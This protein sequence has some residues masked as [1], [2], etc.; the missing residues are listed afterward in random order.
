[1]NVSLIFSPFSSVSYVPLGISYLKSFIEKNIPS[2]RVKNLDLSNNFYHNLDKN[3]FL[4]CLEH[5]CLICPGNHKPECKGILRKKE[6]TDLMKAALVS[7]M[8]ITDSETNE[9]YNVAKYN[10][11][12]KVY[13]SIYDQIVFCIGRVLKHSL[14][15]GREENNIIL[16]NG[17]FKDDIDRILSEGPEVVGFSIFSNS[18]LNYSLALARILKAKINPRIVFGGAAISHLDKKAILKIFDFIDFIIY[19]EGEPGIVGLLKNFKKR[20][21]NAVPNLVY[22]KGDKIIENKES[23]VCNLDQIPPPDLS[24]Y[25]LKQYFTPCPVLSTLFS[26]GCFWSGCTFCAHYK[27]YSKPYRTRSI[28]NIILELERYQKRGINHIW[29]ADESIS[30]VDL[31]LINKGLLKKKIKIYYGVMLKPTGDFTYEILKRMHKA[32]CRLVVWG[33]ESFSQ[34]ILNLMNKG[35]NVQEI[36]NVLK[37]SYKVGL[38]NH[39]YM[40]RWFPTQTEGEILK[41]TEILKKKSKYLYGFDVHDFWLEDDTFI[42][43]SPEK[44]E[45]KYLKRR[46][47]LKIKESKLFSSE[48][49]FV[50]KNKI[51]RRRLSKL[52]MRNQK[53]KLINKFDFGGWEHSLLHSTHNNFNQDK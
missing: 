53:Y 7:K 1:L 31:D 24:D 5:L 16:E 26:R 47:L 10:Q 11:L 6:F 17:L 8:C 20:S 35:T 9:F 44:F 12:S 18:Q 52:I 32:G 49:S 21:F 25:N 38:H 41:D 3:E 30:S 2:V 23:V 36:D 33:V 46:C 51:D 42:F 37:N 50:N 14:E 39:I 27:T 45:L 34:R 4:N 19:K 15:F 29:F 48:F 28:S 13:D 43:K 40:I 22:R